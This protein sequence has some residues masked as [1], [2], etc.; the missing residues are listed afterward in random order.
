MSLAERITEILRPHMGEH[1]ADS[2]ARHLCA[3]HGVGDGPLTAETRA[4]LHETLRRGLV[5]FV[6]A[7][8]AD[9]LARQCFAGGEPPK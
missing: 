3:K 8:R 7:A 4:Q 9:E 1:T 6:G 2:V 5:A